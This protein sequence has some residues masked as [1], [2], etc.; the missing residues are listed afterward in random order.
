MTRRGLDHVRRVVPVAVLV[1]VSSVTGGAFAAPERKSHL[2]LGV[3]YEVHYV[4]PEPPP[5][6]PPPTAIPAP[7]VEPPDELRRGGGVRFGIC[8]ALGG[9]W[10]LAPSVRLRFG[11]NDNSLIGGVDLDLRHY[12]DRFTGETLSPYVLGGLSILGGITSRGDLFVL[13]DLLVQAG[14]GLDVRIW[15]TVTIGL[16]LRAAYAIGD[17]YYGPFEAAVILGFDL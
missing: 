7:P 15:H 9:G 17:T 4:L 13:P 5:D 14:G 3:L 11:N 10:A 12:F 2:E 8:A 1:A 16:A 6:P